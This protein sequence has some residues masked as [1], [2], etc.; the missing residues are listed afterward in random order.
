MLVAGVIHLYS[1]RCGDIARGIIRYFAPYALKESTT[2]DKFPR[3]DL[4]EVLALR[5]QNKAFVVLVS[6]L[7][8]DHEM[9][10]LIEPDGDVHTSQTYNPFIYDLQSWK[11]TFEVF[12]SSLTLLV[13][14]RK[15]L[16]DNDTINAYCNL[17]HVHR[18]FKY[19]NLTSKVPSNLTC[20]CEELQFCADGVPVGDHASQVIKT[21]LQFLHRLQSQFHTIPS[22]R[23][24]AWQVSR[25]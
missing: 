8:L 1:S 12:Y 16:W 25:V 10:F 17:T 6:I 19:S 24:G 18:A 9:A 2:E 14:K 23:G 21:G 15:C 5:V 13:D 22:V 7:E 20:V 11:M 4:E 3:L